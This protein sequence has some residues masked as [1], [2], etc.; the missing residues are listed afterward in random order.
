MMKHEGLNQSEILLFVSFL[1]VAS[2]P[3]EKYIA[4]IH[5]FFNFL[6]SRLWSQVSLSQSQASLPTT[7]I[8]NTH[9]YNLLYISIY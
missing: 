6:S 2:L 1:L 8:K 3:T 7:P 5:N 4:L 9:A